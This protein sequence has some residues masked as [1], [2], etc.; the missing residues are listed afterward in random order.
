MKKRCT[1]ASAMASPLGLETCFDFWQSGPL[2]YSGACTILV[3]NVE[4]NLVSAY[5]KRAFLRTTPTFPLAKHVFVKARALPNDKYWQCGNEIVS[6]GCF[7]AVPFAQLELW[8]KPSQI[9]LE[10]AFSSARFPPMRYSFLY[11]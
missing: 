2:Y 4:I 7:Q 8:L 5:F 11:F 10:P 1:F 6:V 9:S 3:D